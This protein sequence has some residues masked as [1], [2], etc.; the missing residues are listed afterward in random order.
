[1]VFALVGIGVVLGWQ[2]TVVFGGNR[3]DDA[4]ANIEG[5]GGHVRRW[6]RPTVISLWDSDRMGDVQS[7]GFRN[8]A[9]TDDDLDDIVS[10]RRC[11]AVGFVECT[12]DD[13]K[14]LV[15]LKGMPALDTLVLTDC[16]L[17]E[18]DM[19]F[20]FSLERLR[21]LYL[22]GNPITDDV[23]PML[24][25]VPSL[26]A[27]SVSRTSLTAAGVEKLKARFEVVP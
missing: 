13:R 26:K 18:N 5:H 12:F 2:L 6:S 24:M 9:I 23:I 17:S 15:R 14:R 3:D 21:Y 10:L 16:G 22:D 19:A 1:M 11:I 20:L 4:V 25:K 8:H 7:V 27:V